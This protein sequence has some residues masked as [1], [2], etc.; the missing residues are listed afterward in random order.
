MKNLVHTGKIFTIENVGPQQSGKY[1]C[2]T[3]NDGL[4]KSSD[5]NYIELNVTCKC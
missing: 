1:F 3:M 5:S 4:I 2:N